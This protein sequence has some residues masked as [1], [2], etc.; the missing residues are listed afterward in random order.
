LLEFVFYS[1]GLENDPKPKISSKIVYFEN[2]FDRKKL[3]CS[4]TGRIIVVS[5]DVPDVPVVVKSR[6]RTGWRRNT[7]RLPEA[8]GIGIIPISKL[9]LIGPSELGRA[10]CYQIVPTADFTPQDVKVKIPPTAWGERVSRDEDGF[11]TRGRDTIFSNPDSLSFIYLN[12]GVFPVIPELQALG[13]ELTGYLGSIGIGF[14]GIG[15]VG[16]VVES[17]RLLS[18]GMSWSARCGLALA[19]R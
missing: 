19:Q 18:A 16:D 17:N 10:S 14:V 12:S 7:V 8:R 13:V 9:E 3:V 2:E 11:A 5:F 15:P 4:M 6:T 1:K